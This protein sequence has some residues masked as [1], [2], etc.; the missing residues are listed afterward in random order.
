M[1]EIIR[2]AETRQRNKGP[3]AGLRQQ[4]FLTTKMGMR[5]EG[6]TE[7]LFL[8]GPLMCEVLYRHI[9]LFPELNRKKSK[10]RG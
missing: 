2:L 9:R 6:M 1:V 7:N 5:M 3:A 8:W 10:G 4:R